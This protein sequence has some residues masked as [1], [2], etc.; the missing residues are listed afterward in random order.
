MI[1]CDDKN[2]LIWF[3]CVF[4]SFQGGPTV[5]WCYWFSLK[6][7]TH[8]YF[9]LQG[10]VVY[11]LT[12]FMI[13]LNSNAKQTMSS[14]ILSNLDP[15][16]PSS[17]YLCPFGSCPLSVLTSPPYSYHVISCTAPLSSIYPTLLR[18]LFSSSYQKLLPAPRGDIHPYYNI[19]SN[20]SL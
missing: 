20:T 2:L 15:S 7:M 13:S 16:S 11:S 8:F 3:S 10:S 14:C 4:P 12:E 5:D 1:Y 9:L 17:L 6:A 18:H 19:D